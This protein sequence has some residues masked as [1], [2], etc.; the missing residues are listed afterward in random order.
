LNAA[1]GRIFDLEPVLRRSI[2][3]VRLRDVAANLLGRPAAVPVIDLA[4]GT[5]DGRSGTLALQNAS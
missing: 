5:V 4:S 2:R 1:D 3:I